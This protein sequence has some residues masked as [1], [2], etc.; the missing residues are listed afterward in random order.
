MNESFLYSLHY[1]INLFQSSGVLPPEL[2]DLVSSFYEDGN[3]YHNAR[4]RNRQIF[5]WNKQ[6]A[7][8][9][10]CYLKTPLI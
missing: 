8:T 5:Y 3:N 2:N 4:Q 7:W 6:V 1:V 9:V 10:L